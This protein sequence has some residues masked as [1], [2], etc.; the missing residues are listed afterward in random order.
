MEA[1]AHR[2][3]VHVATADDEHGVDAQ[4]FGVLNLRL[5]RVVAEVGAHAA[6]RGAQFLRD[7][8]RVFHEQ[9]G[10][11][12]VFRA[13]GDDAHLIRREP[14]REVARVMFSEEAEES[15]MRAPKFKVICAS[16]RSVRSR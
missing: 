13:D 11:G 2:D 10:R 12:I 5:D 3:G 16:G 7:V 9:G 15:F 1:D 4:L 6:L 14:E 8:L